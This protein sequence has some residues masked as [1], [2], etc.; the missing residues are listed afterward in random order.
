MSSEKSFPR[1]GEKIVTDF[2]GRAAPTYLESETYKLLLGTRL[3]TLEKGGGRTDP[4]QHDDQR[5]D[6][7]QLEEDA[8]EGSSQRHTNFFWGHD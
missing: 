4:R 5:S 6:L 8:R 2:P 1:L 7:E 3:I